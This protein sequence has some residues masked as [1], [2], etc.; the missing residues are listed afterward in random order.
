MASRITI[1]GYEVE[2]PKPGGDCTDCILAFNEERQPYWRCEVLK[3]AC[4]RALCPRRLDLWLKKRPR[5][6]AHERES[7]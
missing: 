4:G 7:L 2:W 3:A 5:D 6:A 1:G